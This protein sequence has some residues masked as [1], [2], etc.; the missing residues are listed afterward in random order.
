MDAVLNNLAQGASEFQ[1][2]IE[3]AVKTLEDEK[4]SLFAEREALNQ[5]RKQLEHEHRRVAEIL[6]NG[7]QVS[8]ETKKK[9]SG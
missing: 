7:E 4:K 9:G 8:R 5:E 2:R 3:L 1:S 6:S